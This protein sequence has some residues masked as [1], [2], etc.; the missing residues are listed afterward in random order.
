MDR[1]EPEVAHEVRYLCACALHLNCGLATSVAGS[2]SAVAKNAAP[3]TRNG[4]GAGTAFAAVS[5]TIRASTRSIAF[6]AFR[7]IHHPLSEAWALCRATFLIMRKRGLRG[8]WYGHTNSPYQGQA[9]TACGSGPTRALPCG[10]LPAV[11]T[12]P[13][14]RDRTGLYSTAWKQ[15]WSIG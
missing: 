11:S 2:A 5:A 4:L 8:G 1:Y 12:L 6:F 10:A 3:A 14:R 7:H 13:H 9:G 15:I